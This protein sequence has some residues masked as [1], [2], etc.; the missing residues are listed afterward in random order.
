MSDP[1]TFGAK[2]AL[3]AASMALTATQR[4]EGPRLKS[5]DVSV[6]DYGTPFAEVDGYCRIDGCPISWSPPLREEEVE[7]KTKG[8]KYTN[9]R[10]FWTGFVV[11]AGHEV[12][13]IPKIRMDNHL[14]LDM[15]KAGPIS[16][17]A[18]LFGGE[19][20]APVKLRL[21]SNLRLYMG[22]ETQEIDPTY[23][24]WCEDRY[25]P[26]SA[27]ARRGVAGAMFIDVPVEK[28]GNRVPQIS[29]DVVNNPDPA[30]LS[31]SKSS[32]LAGLDAFFFSPDYGRFYH[33][34]DVWDTATRTKLR[35]AS[36]TRR[37]AFNADGSFYVDTAADD[38]VLYSADGI[39]LSTTEVTTVP[40][41]VS[42]AKRAGSLTC[43]YRFPDSLNGAYYWDGDAT[44][45]EVTTNVPIKCYFTGNDGETYAIGGGNG[46]FRIYELPNG[47]YQEVASTENSTVCHAFANGAGGIVVVH[48]N[49][50]M[51]VDTATWTVTE[52]TNGVSGISAEW[53]F[54]NI[55]PGT[56]T[57]W[58]S[59]SEYSS[60]TVE[61]LRT[62][63]PS[64]W[65]A[66]YNG[67]KLYDP[68]NHAIIN[69]NS[70]TGV[71]TWLYLD[72]VAE[73]QTTLASITSAKCLRRGIPSDAFDVTDIP[74]LVPGYY[75]IQGTGADQLQPLYD[76]HDVDCVPHDFGIK[77][78]T[79][80]NAADELIETGDFRSEGGPRFDVSIVAATRLPW[81]AEFNYADKTAD[82]QPNTAS[83]TMPPDAVN[84]QNKKVFDLSTYS[85]EP[86]SA[87]PKV[88]RY[89][90]RQWFERELGEATLTARWAK[91]EPGDIKQ[92]EI[93]GD[94]RNVRITEITRAGML[95]MAKWVRDDPRVHD[96]SASAGP[97]FDGRDL[98]EIYVP[99]PAKAVVADV[100]LLNDAENDNNPQIHYAVGNYGGANFPG[101]L[102]WQGSYAEDGYQQWNG[103]DSAEKAVWGYVESGLGTDVDPWM[104]DYGST[105]EVTIYGGT[106]TS[107]TEAEVLADGTINQA[108]IGLAGRWEV[109]QFI[110]AT[111]LGDGVWE[112]SGLLRGRRGTEWAIAFHAA[113]DEFWLVEDLKRDIMGL[114]D[115]GS[116]L[117]FKGQTVGR[118]PMIAPTITIDFE[119][120]TLMPYAPILEATQDGTDWVIT[121]TRRTRVGGT[122]LNGT[123]IP[124]SE[125]SEAYALVI[126]DG[127]DELRTLTTTVNGD[128]TF[129]ATYSGA[130]QTTDFGAPINRAALLDALVAYQLSDAVGRGFPST[131]AA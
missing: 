93:D 23:E 27:T 36:E 57:F 107:S 44:I 30:Y 103:V 59:N 85:D 106:L 31:E 34:G 19:A 122:I 90:R 111:L 92:V 12:D 68:V 65:G 60:T 112:L 116:D 4:F 75:T 104:I 69:H 82:H 86:D 38:M 46:F 89:L 114:S 10:Y 8:G 73:G 43:L 48:G 61:L 91:L 2:L 25:G 100:P 22:T 45:Y 130:D 97:T 70:T 49:S 110:T 20:G 78:V 42:G 105:V 7:S 40:D 76:I 124:L 47:T 117:Y 123:T 56:A 109:I 101:G 3:T 83:D 113:G 81:R 39:A 29:M 79:R 80:G 77:F 58:L 17:L 115:L 9:Y 118:D 88:E 11:A 53:A 18:G 63:T 24:A 21:G 54:A 126:M 129:E 26:D 84:S 1:V 13:A 66:S 120:Q 55:K 15:T 52:Q 131:L 72:R 32:S 119:A 6:A 14:V 64:D 127:D 16:I 28:F 67:G 95:V 50:A 33:F 62:I 128:G 35:D 121:G 98:E 94:N 51:L 87:Q 37:R 102:I 71:L 74:Q 125:N 41:A 99:S 5:V 108:I 96:E